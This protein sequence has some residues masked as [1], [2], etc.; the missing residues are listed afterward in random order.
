MTIYAGA[1]RRRSLSSSQ[2]TSASLFASV[3]VQFPSSQSQRATP[4]KPPDRG[5][6]DAACPRSGS[7]RTVFILS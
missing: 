7:G 3:N 5:S 6:D 2:Q 1:E 4:E